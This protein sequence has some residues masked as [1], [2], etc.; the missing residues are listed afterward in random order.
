MEEV[1]KLLEAID[2]SKGGGMIR[3]DQAVGCFCFYGGRHGADLL[4]PPIMEFRRSYV[5]VGSVL[6][7]TEQ[8]QWAHYPCWNID[9]L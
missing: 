9:D 2:T 3:E 7:I 6:A 5:V 8:T 4:I 1:V